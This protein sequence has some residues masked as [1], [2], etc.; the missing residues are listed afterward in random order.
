MDCTGPEK[1][2]WAMVNLDD[3]THRAPW[4][5]S[6]FMEIDTK[7]YKCAGSGAA[8]PGAFL[9]SPDEEMC[10]YGGKGIACSE[11]EE[12]HRFD[13]SRCV[14]CAELGPFGPVAFFVL[15]VVLTVVLAMGTRPKETGD[16]FTMVSVD[17]MRHASV[18]N[19]C[20]AVLMN[21]VQTTWMVSRFSIDMPDSTREP[22]FVMGSIFD[23]SA[24]HLDCLGTGEFQRNYAVIRTVLC[25][26]IPALVI[27]WMALVVVAGQ[28]AVKVGKCTMKAP[29]PL[30]AINSLVGLFAAFFMAIANA[31]INDGF[32]IYEHPSQEHSLKSFP[33]LLSS[34]EEANQMRLVS[35]FGIAIWCVGG[36]ALI[37]YMQFS[38]PRRRE[39][40]TFRQCCLSMVVK[41]SPDQPWWYLVTLVTS[42]L[43]T[44]SVSLFEDGSW[45]I[46]YA[47]IVLVAY[48]SGLLVLM[49]LYVLWIFLDFYCR[50]RP[51]DLENIM[52]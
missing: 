7:A 39:D 10:A 34:S 14:S 12:G 23:L 49:L 38:L 21:L 18:L 43:I 19:Q 46:V 40:K 16:K 5:P 3:G 32:A 24:F 45:Q 22:L 25:N 47:L 35:G 27:I 15:L 11:W 33:F 42:F 8:C 44:L 13:G 20:F 41:Y 36:F 37:T 1:S 30:F 28:V 9:G 51:S 4:L 6:G 48:Y 29:H 17:R 26:V 31:A 50:N 52:A 2:P